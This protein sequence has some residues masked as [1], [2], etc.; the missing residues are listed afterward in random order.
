MNNLS[1][2]RRRLVS[3]KQTRQITGAMETVSVSKM[4]KATERYDVS[5]EYIDAVRDAACDVASQIN[6]LYTERDGI[7]IPSRGEAVFVFSAD[8]GMC[9]AFNH[10]VLALAESVINERSAI[11]PVGKLAAERLVKMENVDTRFQ[12]DPVTYDYAF[13]Q[14]LASAA[15]Y[16]FENG[17]SVRF[18]YNKLLSKAA[19]E[20]CDVSV[21][22]MPEKS[23]EF[24]EASD[25]VCERLYG[26]YSECEAYCALL[27]SIAAEHIARHAAMS[28]STRSADEM[29][30]ALSVEYNRAR[31]GYVTE[32]ITEI[33]GSAS[34]LN[35]RRP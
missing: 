19:Y 9:G 21:F 29:I 14:K 12:A 35:K 4:R 33:I 28:A 6:C 22:P 17:Y 25:E 13:A 27:E 31:Q 2:I 24:S 11:V 23:R 3:V 30:A 34:A 32:Q 16:Y 20:P 7:R 5:R 15:R 26:M 18:V 1:D 8:K 10:D